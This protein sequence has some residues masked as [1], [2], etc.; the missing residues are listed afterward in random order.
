MSWLQLGDKQSETPPTVQSAG[1]QEGV[2]P[3]LYT[4]S[5]GV[6]EAGGERL[7]KLKTPS[8][9]SYRLTFDPWGSH[10]SLAQKNKNQS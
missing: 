6:R 9:S 5:V 10:Q 3:P 8:L 4:I 1:T 2:S 7:L